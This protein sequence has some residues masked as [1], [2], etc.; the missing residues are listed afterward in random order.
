[1]LLFLISALRAVIEM[2]GLAL[3]GLALMYV[4]AGSQRDKNPIYQLFALITRA[5]RRLVACLLRNKVGPGLSGLL[6]FVLLLALWVG[7]AL[8][9]AALL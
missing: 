6:C 1:M 2:L 9:R 4:L 7:L 3:L 5:P 8:W